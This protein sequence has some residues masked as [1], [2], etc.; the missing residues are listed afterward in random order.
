M[1]FLH[2]PMHPSPI[3]YLSPG[4]RRASRERSIPGRG[5]AVAAGLLSL[6]GAGC[7][8]CRSSKPYTPYTLS[9]NPSASASGSSAPSGG[10]PTEDM[11]DAASPADAGPAFPVV[12]GAPPAGDGKSWPLT[13]DTAVAAPVGRVFGVGLVVDADGDGQRDLI[14]WARAPDGLRGEIWFAGGNKPQSGRTIAA[15]PEGLSAPG[16]SARVELKQV[17]PRTV[18]FDF[19]PRCSGRNRDKAIRW[20]AVLRLPAAGAGSAPEIGI[21]LRFGVPAEGESIQVAVDPRDRDGDGR[22]DITAAITLS[23]SPRPFPAAGAAASASLAFFDRPAGL[24]R[25]PSEPEASLKALAL[26]LVTD[27]RRRT[28]APRIAA[29]ALSLRRLLTLLC[30]E[31]GKPQI[32]TSAGAI[33]CGEARLLED[34]AMAEIEAARN[35]GDP[36]GTMAGLARLDALG[37]RR[38]DVDALITKSIAQVNATPLHKT[39][40]VPVIEP[41]PAFSPLAWSGSGDLL[42]HTQG[43]VIRVDRISFT[44]APVDAALRWP[45]RLAFP[46]DQPTWK[47]IAV[48]RRCDEPTLMGRFETG[49]PEAT[50][51]T[52]IPL[53]IVIPPHC[54]P[55]PRVTAELLGASTQGALVAVGAD[56]IALPLSDPPRP[57]LAESLGLPT[58][59]A[60]ELGAARS[61][62]GATFAIPTGRGLL[63]AT[64]KGASRSATARLWTGIDA[65]AA[66]LCVPS[67]GGDRV[68]CVTPP[69]ATLYEAAR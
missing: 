39:A 52:E 65:S 41:S 46:A 22:D 60:V 32:T 58:G 23:G 31:A 26:G 38:K 17:G 47:L 30:N 6:A 19:E 12:Q 50:S 59:G 57:A 28:T 21:E 13:G 68:A 11:A 37:V 5:I 43:Q 49:K 10:T 8:G 64:A 62:D 56:L 42:V 24:S 45:T 18:V 66:Y 14:A 54:T 51:V 48:E 34:A 40:A 69:A 63:V 4:Q 29:G 44:E 9:D 1:R 16:C 27:A 7:D 25:D 36:I 35:L 67:N 33:R 3:F 15:L 20:V 55:S 61:P 53:P 2:D